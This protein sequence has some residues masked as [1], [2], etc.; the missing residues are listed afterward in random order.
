VIGEVQ[1]RLAARVLR[2]NPGRR[3]ATVALRSVGRGPS[4]A[5][6]YAGRTGELALVADGSS[7]RPGLGRHLGRLVKVDPTGAGAE[8]DL[9]IKDDEAWQAL[10]AGTARIEALVAFEGSSRGDPV[11][12]RVQR[13]EIC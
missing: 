3:V 10:A 6:A 2:L 5:G 11:N 8:L 12:G 13:I 4:F 7:I 1:A 9:V